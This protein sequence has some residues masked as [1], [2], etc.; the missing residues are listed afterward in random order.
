MRGCFLPGLLV[1]LTL[2]VGSTGAVAQTRT[3]AT[4]R[5][6]RAAHPSRTAANSVPGSMV[7]P[8][9]WR[10]TPVAPAAGVPWIGLTEYD[11]LVKGPTPATVID[12]R[13]ATTFRHGHLPNARSLVASQAV[14]TISGLTGAVVLIDSDPSGA[15]ALTLVNQ[16]RAGAT[17]GGGPSQLV[18]LKGGIAPWVAAGRPLERMPSHFMPEVERLTVEALRTK[19]LAGWRPLIYDTRGE[20]AYASGHAEGALRLDES[21]VTSGAVPKKPLVLYCTCGDDESAVH[22]YEALVAAGYTDV[23]VLRGGLDALTDAGYPTVGIPH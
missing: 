5:A 12:L 11:K 22:A 4:G 21:L 23:H 18:V 6:H 20:T 7:L 10:T 14:P 2:A 19:L 15:G 17:F 3:A 9:R 13:R 16:V 1:G 8:A